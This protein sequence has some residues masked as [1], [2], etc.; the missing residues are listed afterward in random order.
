[1]NAKRKKLVS[2]PN[3]HTK[4]WFSETLL[5]VEMKKASIKMS[6]PIY[7]GLAILSLSKI[8][9]YEYCYDDMKPKYGE[10]IRLCYMDTDNA[11]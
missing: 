5:A 10:N 2:E 7:V 4:K 9:M 11:Y 1:M 3:Y 8:K 6:K